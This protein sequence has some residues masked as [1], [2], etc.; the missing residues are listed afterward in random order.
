MLPCSA[1]SGPRGH[2]G[3]QQKINSFF[4]FYPLMSLLI[5]KVC[6]IPNSYIKYFWSLHRSHHFMCF[7]EWLN[8]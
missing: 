6:I 2:G 3:L 5:L 4:R 1:P 8:A 7:G